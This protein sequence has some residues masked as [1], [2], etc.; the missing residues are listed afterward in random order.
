MFATISTFLWFFI[1]SVILISL[2]IL[3]EEK[4]I[5][6]EEHLRRLSRKIARKIRNEI[7]F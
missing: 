7:A 1:P 5:E 2:G 6:F 4:L 3:F